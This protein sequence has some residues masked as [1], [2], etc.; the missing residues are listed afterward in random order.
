VT[1]EHPI[2]TQLEAARQ[3]SLRGQHQQAVDLCAA[4]LQQSPG[5]PRAIAFLALSLWRASAFAQA[6]EVLG[7]ALTQFPAQEELSFALLDSLLALRRG[8]QALQFAATLPPQLLEKPAFRSRIEDRLV[9]LLNA[10]EFVQVEKEMLPLLQAQP[11]WG[12]GQTLLASVMFNCSGR[13][14]CSAALKVDDAIESAADVEARW[15]RDL[16]DAMSAYRRKI[17]HQL[18]TALSLNPMDEHARELRCRTRFEEGLD[19][20]DADVGLVEQQLGCA[21][22]GPFPLRHVLEPARADAMHLQL[23]ESSRLMVIPAPRSIGADLALEGSV[24]PALVGARYVA[25]AANAMVV[26]GSDVVLLASGEAWCDLLTHPLGEFASYFSDRWIALGS[27]RLL[28]LRALPATPIRGT[29]ISLLGR[30]T[31]FFGHWLLDSLIRL[32]SVEH[33]P[34]YG[35]AHVLV[36]DGMADTHYEALRLLLG[37]RMPLRRIAPGACVQVDRL[38]F[39][40]AEVFFPHATRNG[41]PL[42][43]SVAPSRA[44]GLAWLRERMLGALAGTLMPRGSRLLLRR[45]SATRRVLNEDAVCDL[46]VRDWGF[47]VLYPETLGFAD[48]V[49]RLH[50]AEVVVGAQ[51][52]AMSNCV[53][54]A[55]GTRVVSICS[56]FAGNF[57]SWADAL[58]QL[59]I[60]HCFLACEAEADSHPL[61][62]QRHLRVDLQALVDALLGVG[63]M[64]SGASA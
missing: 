28:L 57:P 17:L 26:A 32:R 24:G 30:A 50:A 2:A 42:C 18:D 34:A 64:P 15:R 55:P 43:P 51:G 20:D 56:R 10:G 63:V 48:Q 37:P 6:V 5:E 23:L 58:E 39:S 44:D 16:A 29:A 22:A 25:E 8:E 59:G 36:E 19:T 14:L 60:Q 61:P 45:R 35:S 1:S 49:R 7:Q 47:E 4:A 54:C 46:L 38:L 21:F 31:E 12:F 41:A 13:G 27:T 11:R 40:G 62:I 52:S 53:F 9:K 33:H 3:A